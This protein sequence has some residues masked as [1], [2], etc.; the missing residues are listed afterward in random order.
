M[1]S[2]WHGEREIVVGLQREETCRDGQGRWSDG[3]ELGEAHSHGLRLT[4]HV[5][6][7][8]GQGEVKSVGLHRGTR[9][10]DRRSHGCS[11]CASRL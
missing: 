4:S 11:S 8:W 1:S 7:V 2:L 3:R 6:S 10:K 5:F 9:F